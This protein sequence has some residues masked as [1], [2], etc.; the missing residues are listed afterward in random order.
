M[1]KNSLPDIKKIIFP[2]GLKLLSYSDSIKND[3]NGIFEIGIVIEKDSL[4]NYYL[5]CASTNRKSK[6]LYYTQNRSF[7]YSKLKVY[8]RLIIA[9]AIDY[10]F[11]N[12]KPQDDFQ[13]NIYLK[14]C[15]EFDYYY[16]KDLIECIMRQHYI[17][18]IKYNICII[19]IELSENNLKENESKDTE[20]INKNILIKNKMMMISE[21]LYDDTEKSSS[22][23]ECMK[24]SASFIEIFYIYNLY[25]AALFHATKL[26]ET[27]KYFNLS[28]KIVQN[29]NSYPFYLR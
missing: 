16:I 13:I 29:F 7:S 9:I 14:I 27:L 22:I 15:T 1:N 6:Y 21:I 10:F 11:L 12:D 25:P 8:L 17:I 26:C 3:N 19:K 24:E 5:F 4:N 20:N 28:D 2:I 23:F 18:L